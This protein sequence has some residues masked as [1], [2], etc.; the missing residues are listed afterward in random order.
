MNIKQALKLLEQGKK[1]SRWMD[2]TYPC[3]MVLEKSDDCESQSC[4]FSIWY[5]KQ[6]CFAN[7]PIACD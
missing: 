1:V 5:P 4:V 7:A 6:I 3:Y 2:D